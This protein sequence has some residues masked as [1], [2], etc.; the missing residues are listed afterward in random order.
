MQH[1]TNHYKKGYY[2][3]HIFSLKNDYLI[4]YLWPS[5]DKVPNS[6]NENPRNFFQS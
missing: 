4:I 6:I 1:K 3:K 2:V 5:L